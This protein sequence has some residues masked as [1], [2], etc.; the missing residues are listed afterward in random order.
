M[1]RLLTVVLFIGLV[2]GCGDDEGV[3]PPSEPRGDR[4]TF[5]D[6]GPIHV[7]G[8]GINPKD[9]ALFIATHTGLFRAPAG[10]ETARRVAGRFQDTMGFT[11]V[12]PNTFL[13]SGHPDAREDL[14]PFLGLIR[15]TDAGRSWREVS[16][17]GK[18][19]FHVLEASGKRVYGFGS[20]Y[21][22]R[23]PEFLVSDDGGES[24]D[25]RSPPGGIASLAI[26]PTD[27]QK[28]VAAIQGGPG[29]DGLHASDDAGRTWQPLTERVG[30]LAWT[31]SELLALVDAEG[32][33]SASEDGG[34]EWEEVG[35]VG[36]EPAAFDAAGDDLLAALHDGTVKQSGDGG[37]TWSVRSVPRATVTE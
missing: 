17:M 37:R 7:H 15:S 5:E 4:P 10:E 6:P 26:S 1:R 21:E 29:D 14:P 35:E 12:G 28:V 31:E 33:V 22:A 16:L 23:E 18:S 20:N 34:E 27:P 9:R 11:V 25:K 19:D 36:G 24:W 8:L 13:G 3:Q 32:V 2:A 30:L